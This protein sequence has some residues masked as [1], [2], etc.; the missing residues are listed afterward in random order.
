MPILRRLRP[1]AWGRQI[2]KRRLQLIWLPVALFAALDTLPSES[3]HPPLT[4]LVVLITAA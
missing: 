2:W 4:V 1:A 3:W